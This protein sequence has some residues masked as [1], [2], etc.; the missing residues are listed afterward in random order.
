MLWQV[1]L[2]KDSV[3]LPSVWAAREGQWPLLQK[4]EGRVSMR[5]GGLQNALVVYVGKTML[6][7]MGSFRVCMGSRSSQAYTR[8][9]LPYKMLS[10]FPVSKA[11]TSE[12]WV[13]VAK[14][15]VPL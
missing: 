9:M 15:V 10:P 8:E 2:V 1:R 11:M 13:N 14:R 6:H 7:A 3:A 12:L 4:K 5:V